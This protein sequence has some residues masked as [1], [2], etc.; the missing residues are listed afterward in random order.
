M[1]GGLDENGD[2]LEK[3]KWT[4]TLD[5]VTM[6]IYLDPKTRASNLKVNIRSDT[7][8]VGLKSSSDWIING[9]FPE[10]VKPEDSFWSVDQDPNLGTI[11]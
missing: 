7:L 6:Q 4:Q 2:T 3:Y 9:K 5:E 11:L 8:Q 10:K 1:D